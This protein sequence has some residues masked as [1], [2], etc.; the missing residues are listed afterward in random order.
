MSSLIV[1]VCKISEILPHGNADALEICVIKG[2]KSIVKKGQFQPGDK[3][4]Y[5]PPDCVIPQETSEKWGVTKYLSPVR[6]NG[7]Q[8]GGRVRVTRLR[9]EP[10][11]GFVVVPEQDWD[12]GTDVVEH[13]KITKYEPP[14]SNQDGD[15]AKECSAFHRYTDWENIN[16][17]PDLIQDGEEVEITEKLHGKNARTGYIKIADENGNLSYEFMAGSHSFRRKEF[18]TFKKVKTNPETGLEEEYEVTKKSQFWEVFDKQPNLKNLMLYLCNNREEGEF[19][20]HQ[21]DVMVF[22]EL[23]GSGIQDLSYGFENGQSDFRVFD[24]SVNGKYLDT[25]DRV[26]LCDRFQ[27]ARVPLL[28]IGPFSRAKVDELVGGPTT[29]CAPEK[30]KGFKER[31]GVVIK[32]TKE[33]SRPHDRKFF[34]RVGVKAINFNYLERKGGTEEH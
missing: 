2:W 12:V 20:T 15:A 5:V 9:G 18:C 8:I 27:I 28:Y 26:E 14:V 1:E 22:G 6:E 11:Y 21:N 34:N 10:S 24:I 3:V 7:V 25:H 29:I 31:E 17:F 4:V 16:N 30:I 23:F 32:L 13:F 19:V 33:A